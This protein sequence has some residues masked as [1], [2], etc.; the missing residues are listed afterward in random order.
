MSA[1]YMSDPQ[2][3]PYAAGTIA[4]NQSQGGERNGE[5]KDS[6]RAQD[7]VELNDQRMNRGIR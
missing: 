2:E 5:N 4:A 3:C 1:T 6:Q 7:P